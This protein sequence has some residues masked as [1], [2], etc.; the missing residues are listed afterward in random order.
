M[1]ASLAI[2]I[3]IYGLLIVVFIIAIILP[4][5]SFESKKSKE[6]EPRLKDNESNK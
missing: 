4:Y 6:K 1:T 5:P 3:L 2:D